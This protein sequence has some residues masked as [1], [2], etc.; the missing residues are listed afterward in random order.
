MPVVLRDLAVSYSVLNANTPSLLIPVLP[1]QVFRGRLR[2]SFDIGNYP[3][4][5]M[6]SYD[7]V[8]DGDFHTVEF[9]IVG[10]NFTMR[11]DNGVSQTIINEG[12]RDLLSMDDPHIRHADSFG[13]GALS[14]CLC[15]ML[16]SRERNLAKHRQ[17]SL[18]QLVAGI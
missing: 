6:F 2:V 7:K 16:A 13:G 3:V 1:L 8:N 5:T 17:T 4:S 12:D 11:V 18:S 10:K 14:H 9:I 15:H